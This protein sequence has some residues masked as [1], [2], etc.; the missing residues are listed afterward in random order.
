MDFREKS[1]T[2]VKTRW[3]YFKGPNWSR[4]KNLS[5]ITRLTRVRKSSIRSQ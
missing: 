4:K 2:L 5:W 1:G 3:E